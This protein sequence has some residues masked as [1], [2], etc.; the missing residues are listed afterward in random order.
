MLSYWL[1][2]SRRFFRYK[3]VDSIYSVRLSFEA[4]VLETIMGKEERNC[5]K[6]GV[7]GEPSKK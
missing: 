7:M 3:S 2:I 4:E 5:K 1:S 6:T